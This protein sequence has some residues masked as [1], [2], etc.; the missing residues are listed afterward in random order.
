[1]SNALAIAAVT[2]TIR[3]LLQN[4]LSSNPGTTPFGGS[5]N[6]SAIAPDRI[7]IENDNL[8]QLNL[9]LYHVTPNPGWRNAALPSHDALGQRLTNPPLALD[10]HYLL[11]AYSQQDFQAEILLGYAMHIL[12]ETPVLP[13]EAIR[14]TLV[15]PDGVAPGSPA[16]VALID[17]DLADQ[18]ELIKVTP[19]SLTSEE[20]YRLWG[21][22]QTSYRP[23]VAYHVSVVLIEGERGTRSPLPVLTRGRPVLNSDRDEGIM[24]KANLLPPFP[25]LQETSP[26]NRQPSVRMG[27]VLSCSGHHLAGDQ[28]FVRFR[29][30]RLGQLL[31]IPASPSVPATETGFQVQIPSVP[32]PGPIV[33]DS[34]LHPDN[35]RA[36]V[37]GLS[38]VIRRN[39]QPD[40]VTNELPLA[41]APRISV[42]VSLPDADGNVTFTAT[43]KP[44]VWQ[45]QMPTLIVG[46]RELVAQPIVVP[47]TDTLTLTA[48]VA[49]LPTG[50]QWVRLRVDGIESI[51]I[52][53]T[54]TPPIFDPT[55]Q[56][57][58]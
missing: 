43:V 7:R 29:H 50:P 39:G 53:R 2:A 12:H 24:V 52:D 37:Y 46:D 9:F 20:I 5:V 28:V 57:T 6:V 15:P 30:S 32:P 38:A 26:P 44:M 33:A 22:F 17:S 11:S 54:K 14:A 21:A 56:V 3:D 40:R 41:L 31:E 36:G 13:R 42:V 1:M 55:Q 48:N 10:L 35:W 18:V 58:L 4:S 47:K 51:L 23:S 27:D 19:Q 49:D 45:A 16:E 34:P 25:T 8:V